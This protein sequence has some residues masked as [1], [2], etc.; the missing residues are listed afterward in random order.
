MF[1]VCSVG[2]EA[3]LNVARET[4]KRGRG[5]GCGTGQRRRGEVEGADDDDDDSNSNGNDIM[6]ARGN[7]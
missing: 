2:A 7:K 5:K 4:G 1:L 3:R 6:R